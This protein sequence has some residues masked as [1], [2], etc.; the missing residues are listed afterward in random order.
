MSIGRFVVVLAGVVALP[1]PLGSAEGVAEPSN[2]RSAETPLGDELDAI[3]ARARVLQSEANELEVLL[4]PEVTTIRRVLARQGASAELAALIAGSLVK[5]GRRTGIAPHLLLA[6]ML[7]ENPWIK[8]DTTSHM[9]AIG[10]MQV[11]PFHAGAWDCPEG[12]LTI[13][14]VNIC[15]GARILANALGRSG[16]DLDGALL[17]YNGCVLGANTTDCHEYPSWVRRARASVEQVRE[18]P[19]E[20]E[21]PAA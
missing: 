13:P 2:I 19:D 3:G 6:V 10:L 20:G 15:Y 5:E 16:G 17:R 9:G 21:V 4:S 14:E 12:D 7:V 1:L 8:P 18:M 11:M